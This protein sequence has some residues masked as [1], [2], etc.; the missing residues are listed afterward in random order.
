[1]KNIVIQ[2]QNFLN[3]FLPVSIIITIFN[4][5]STEMVTTRPERPAEVSYY[6]TTTATTATP[7]TATT[8]SCAF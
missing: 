3:L 7:A 5:T 1:M 8:T 2:C 6:T 4:A